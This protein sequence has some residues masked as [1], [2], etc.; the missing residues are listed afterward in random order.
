MGRFVTFFKIV[1]SCAVQRTSF[2]IAFIVL[3]S[4]DG[5]SA[6]TTGTSSSKKCSYATIFGGDGDDGDGDGV[7]LL[8]STSWF[9]VAGNSCS[10]GGCV[11]RGGRGGRSVD[12]TT[13]R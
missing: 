10:D 8:R 1:G 2:I 9:A 4:S 13:T 5:S 6:S 7:F 11:G 3:C 12:G